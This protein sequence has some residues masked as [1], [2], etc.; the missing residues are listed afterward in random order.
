MRRSK[1]INLISSIIKDQ[2][3]HL[4]ILNF[5][6]TTELQTSRV[7]RYAA[8]LFRDNHHRQMSHE[9][10]PDIYVQIDSLCQT[11]GLRYQPNL[12]SINTDVLQSSRY[13]ILPLKT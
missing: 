8:I 3:P 4:V 12:I 5:L 10:S 1:I 2:E 11:A 7:R 6:S 9:R 13:S